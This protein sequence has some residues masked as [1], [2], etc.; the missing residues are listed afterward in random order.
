M[1]FTQTKATL[2]QVQFMTTKCGF[3]LMSMRI[4]K[5]PRPRL[6]PFALYNSPTR[7]NLVPTEPMSYP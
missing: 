6:V 3:I 5:I 1:M 2:I 4:A 7:L